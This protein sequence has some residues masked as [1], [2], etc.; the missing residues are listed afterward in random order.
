MFYSTSRVSV[1]FYSTFYSNS[2]SWMFQSP[3]SEPNRTGPTQPTGSPPVIPFPRG[4]TASP[5]RSSLRSCVSPRG[6]APGLATAPP[7][8]ARSLRTLTG[9]RERS[10]SGAVEA[11][12]QKTHYMA[13][14][15]EWF[16]QLHVDSTL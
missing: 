10:A 9:W 6:V 4:K 5:R 2:A 13:G 14:A 16:R 7:R 15:G 11:A 8:P 12:G 3:P 1:G